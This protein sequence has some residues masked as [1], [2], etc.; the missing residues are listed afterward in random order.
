MSLFG[1]QAKKASEE[2][3]TFI[4]ELKKGSIAARYE[5]LAKGGNLLSV[6]D[7]QSRAE[8][9]YPSKSQIVG[10]SEK[11]LIAKK[12]AELAKRLAKGAGGLLEKFVALGSAVAPMVTGVFSFFAVAG[13][14]RTFSSRVTQAGQAFEGLSGRY[15]SAM[16]LTRMV[17]LQM[18]LKTAQ[19]TGKSFEFA[20]AGQRASMQAWQPVNKDLKALLNVAGGIAGHTAA[21]LGF[22]ANVAARLTSL[23][24][25]AQ[26]WSNDK[27]SES[28]L[29]ENFR[30]YMQAML[31]GKKEIAGRPVDLNKNNLSSADLFPIIPPLGL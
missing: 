7:V 10:E 13:A 8:T 4:A 19:G 3:E 15:A 25:I 29:N 12:G 27:D 5:R 9:L 20:A 17:E 1:N 22:V 14:L 30:D 11:A 21:V 28:I 2:L 18:Q 16:G 6:A 26:R 23:H 31:E 24:R